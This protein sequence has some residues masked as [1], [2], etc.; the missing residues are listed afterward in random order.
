MREEEKLA[1]DSY[2]LLG[3]EWGLTIFENISV[4]E[5]QHMDAIKNLLDYYQLEDPVINES[6]PGGFVD[7]KLQELFDFLMAWGHQSLTDG[8]YVGAIIEETD[9]I[10]IQHAIERAGHADI[11]S[12]YESLMCGSRN[13][14]RAFVGQIELRGGVYIPFILPAAELE[15]IINSP[16]ERDCGGVDDEITKG[17][18]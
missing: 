6:A 2:W 16:M 7:A 14:L 9:I 13:H 4:S 8:L 5:Q 1:R 17:R 3:E 18:G 11:I 12:T 10:D 15:A